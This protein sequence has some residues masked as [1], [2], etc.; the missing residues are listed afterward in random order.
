M[1]TT[2]RHP[3][4]PAAAS[5]HALPDPGEQV[6]TLSWPI[7][8][9][10][11]FALALFGA[12]TWAALTDTLPAIATIAA[13]STAIFVLFTVLHDA[14]HY[15]ISS[16]RWVNV[17]FGR[18]A[19]FFV[20]PL[21]SFRSFAFIH[22]EHHRNTNDG[23]S[24]P[25]HFVSA[26]PWWQLPLR[27][28]AMDLPYISFLVRN[29]RRRPRAEI[30]ETAALMTLSVTVIAS[31]AFAG[32]LWTLALIYLIPERVAM[33]VLAWWFDWLPHHDL[34]DT[35]RENR[36][37]ATRNRVG[38]E[39]ILTPLLL[40]QNYHLVHHLHPSIPFYRYVAAWRRNE[41]AYLERDSEISTVFGQHLD[42]T[43][44]QE[45]K[46]L[47]GTLAALLPVR[48]PRS[49]AARHASTYPIPVASVEP[50]TP[51]SV[52]VTFAVPD[53]LQDQFA[54]QAGQHLTVHHRIGGK[55]VRRNYSICTCATTG[56]LAIGI[57]RIPG[58]TF[59]SF[60]VD[61][62]RAGDVLELMTPTG[63]FGAPLDP[64]ARHHHVAVAA[65][66]GITPI[67]S[68]LRTT[69]EIETESRFTLFYGNRTAESTMFA[70]ELD[71]LESRYADRLRIFHLRSAE[72][73]HPAALRGRIDLATIQR[74]LATDLT[75][76]DRW[77][78][79][80]P[81][82]LTTTIRDDLATDKVP[83]ERIHLELFRGTN[84]PAHLDNF[85]ASQVTITLS[86]AQ[87]TVELAPG[88][89]V[90]ESALKNNIDAPYA[91]LGGAC[92]TC[93]A[94]VITGK[95]SM[96]QNFA[97]QAAE[98]EAGFILT[99]QSHPTTPTVAV[100]YDS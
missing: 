6:P 86:G 65:G 18:V 100:D 91:C 72:A 2:T 80:G 32:H 51:D 33:F 23:E 79:C 3:Q 81:S 67:L 38:S 9:I 78:L 84:R 20:S 69:M 30:A 55:K 77:Y 53:H 13:S 12:S 60:A 1:S 64:L 90:L 34:E 93:K 54:F 57:R 75:T 66:S 27:F 4:P 73:H 92:G 39:W 8:G 31:A 74:L 87:H 14:S 35:Q 95:V 46:R 56:K 83:T 28:P 68:I 82:E 63:S 62:L 45:W 59:S 98:T 52:T 21:I 5:Q 70:A 85:P 19:M 94:R 61:T 44:Y 15:S 47:N 96:E 10:G 7:V 37:R 25:D 40:S 49:S 42:A 89:T 26:S 88:E 71:E 36:Y 58:G 29:L 22:I 97:L 24:D 43:Q 48:M 16:H 50:L 41:A 99:C 17:A 76:I 11:I